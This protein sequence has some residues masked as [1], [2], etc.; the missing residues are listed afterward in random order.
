[1]PTGTKTMVFGALGP[2]TIIGADEAGL[3]LGGTNFGDI[4][5]ANAKILAPE[6]V[7]N[8][9]AVTNQD[10]HLFGFGGNDFLYGGNGA[11]S[12]F[13]GDGNDRLY[14]F[15]SP[16]DNTNGNVYNGLHGD[17]GD[18]TLVAGSGTSAMDGGDG[19]NTV[20]YELS[21]NGVTV[22]LST[23]PDF[24]DKTH[25]F[26]GVAQDFPGIT[27]TGHATGFS[28]YDILA[29]I[30]GVI[31][32]AHDDVITGNDLDNTVDPGLGDNSIV[33]N[34]GSNTISYRSAVAAVTID[35]VNQTTA[36]S[37]GQGT[38][39]TDH[40]TGFANAYGS[41]FDD[42]ITGTSGDNL[43]DPGLA[44]SVGDQID[45]NGGIDTIA[46]FSALSGVT[47]DLH[48]G[49]AIKTS[50]DGNTTLTDTLTG[51]SFRNIIGSRF[52]DALLRGN[53]EDNIVFYS[54]GNDFIDGI[55][56]IDTLDYHG[57]PG[58]VQIDV[59]TGKTTK[60]IDHGADPSTS[61]GT[62]SFKN[63]EVFVGSV[64]DDT[65]TGGSFSTQKQATAVAMPAITEL[66]FDGGPGKDTF[67]VD[68][69]IGDV[70]IAHDFS[71][72][73][74]DALT[75]LI[76]RFEYLKFD[77]FTV[78]LSRFDA[79]H[80]QPHRR[81]PCRR[82]QRRRADR[83][84]QDR[85]RRPVRRQGQGCAPRSRRRRPSTR[86]QGQ[87]PADRRRRQRH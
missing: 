53:N 45:G 10:S 67:V 34:G 40:Y 28:A 48:E 14:A 64:Y 21:P 26:T 1:M 58:A 55:G 75:A 35:L 68:G 30:Q 87:G 42:M 60:T 24:N 22:D 5:T 32:S 19:Y 82:R 77:D 69:S 15:G 36:K 9:S 7:L 73:G 33:G 84:P 62:D 17:G 76:A 39:Y 72:I 4:I 74:G 29:N 31:G 3:R 66:V 85:R 41:D 56:G 25:N 46:Y 57:A 44:N 54:A 11:D 6:D 27:F 37:D 13:G 79:A 47:V 52:D 43:I 38:N 63:M 18:D 83:R 86:R 71:E 80:H 2:M 50:A 59:T 81:R 12:I 61:A 20:S 16:A 70:D 49:H 65:I 23:P 8:N 78:D 51:G